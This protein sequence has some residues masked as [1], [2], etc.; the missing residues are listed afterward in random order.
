[1]PWITPPPPVKVSKADSAEI[2]KA[3]KKEFP[4]DWALQQVHIARKILEKEAELAGMTLGEY[5]MHLSKRRKWIED[6]K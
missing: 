3:M 4:R 2:S 6:K 1:M 5:H